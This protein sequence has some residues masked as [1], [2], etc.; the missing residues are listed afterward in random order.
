MQVKYHYPGIILLC[1]I[2]M[3]AILACGVAIVP[4]YMAISGHMP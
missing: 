3:V 1:I 2:D 4:G